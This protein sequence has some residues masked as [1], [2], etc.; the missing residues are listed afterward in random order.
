MKSIALNLLTLLISFFILNSCKDPG[1]G[2]DLTPANQINTILTDTSTIRTV[3]VR[4]DSIITTGLTQDP[5]GYLQDPQIGTTESSLA[6]A[7][8]LPVDGLTFGKNA[9]LDSAVLVLNYGKEFYGNSNLPFI[10]NVYQLGEIINPS[11]AYFNTKNWRFNPTIIGSKTIQSFNLKDSLRI[12]DI[13]R[14][15][16]DTSKRVP[17]QLRIPLSGSFINPN[18]L[19]ADSSRFFDNVR[20][21]NFIKGL[22]ITIDH[23][24]NANGI[25]FFNLAST[26]KSGLDLYYKSNNGSLIDT[27]VMHFGITKD[28]TAATIKHTYTSAV[29]TQLSNPTQQFS[30]VYTQ[31]LA[32]LRTKI[33]FPFI[34]SLKALGEIIINKAELIINVEGNSN[35]FFGTAPRLALYHSDIADQR[36]PVPDNNLGQTQ[37]SDPRTLDAREFGGFFDPVHNRY[38]FVITA[39]IQDILSGKLT[40]YNTYIAPVFNSESDAK[41]IF[42]PATGSTAARSIIGGGNSTNYKM[43]LNIIYTKVK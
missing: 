14:G 25:V 8:N 4:E 19:K 43:K 2:L 38:K 32:G 11:K 1:N 12:M 18:F 20:F 42:A 40:Q 37:T 27:T 23:S 36:Q 28:S 13:V 17:P 5:L 24:N 34:K 21:N 39:Y 26:G 31:P 9:A 35:I 15:R 29:Q 22:Y 16:Q 41:L 7:L 33:N 6:I 3:T 30:T 10:V